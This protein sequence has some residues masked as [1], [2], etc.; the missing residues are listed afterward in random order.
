MLGKHLCQGFYI[1]AIH[2]IILSIPSETIQPN[3]NALPENLCEMYDIMNKGVVC[4]VFI[5]T[6]EQ[7]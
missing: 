1:Y 6:L 7:I 5:L 2:V 3:S 4:D